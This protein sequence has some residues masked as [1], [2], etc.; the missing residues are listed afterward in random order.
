MTLSLPGA[1]EYAPFYAG[2]IARVTHVRAPVD[3]LLAQRARLLNLLSPLSDAQGRYRYAPGKWSIK[4]MVGHLADAER[5]SAYRLLRV[6]RGDA[7]PLP[8]WEEEDYVR[9]AGA[10]DRPLGDLLDDWAAARDAT[11]ALVS[12]MPPDAW[13][14]R[15]TVNNGPMSAR[16]LAFILLGHVEHHCSV[17]AERYGIGTP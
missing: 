12:G 7:T 13:S 6:A 2:Y 10:D 1:D 5:I 8:G 4:E 16:A 3:E 9:T 17:L 15:G 14:R 11:I